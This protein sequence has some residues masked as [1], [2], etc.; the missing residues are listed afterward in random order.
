MVGQVDGGGRFGE[1]SSGPGGSIRGG[2]AL[3]FVPA[4]M[5]MLCPRPS[6]IERDAW[7]CLSADHESFA[8]QLRIAM[9][10]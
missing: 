6:A 2:D 8:Y 5:G 7:G 1:F 9:L 4:T 3:R 10:T